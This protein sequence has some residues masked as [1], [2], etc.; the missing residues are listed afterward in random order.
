[1]DTNN[2]RAELAEW[3]VKNKGYINPEKQE[4]ELQKMAAQC[5]EATAQEKGLVDYVDKAYEVMLIMTQQTAP[6]VRQAA[7]PTTPVSGVTAAEEL[8]IANTLMQQQ[9]TRNAV[10]A[11]SSIESLVFDRPDPSTYIAAGTTGLIVE[12]SWKNFMDKITNGTYTVMPDDGEDVEASKRILSTTNFEKLKAAQAAGQPVQIHIGGL[13]TRPIGYIS[14]VGSNTGA[15]NTP[16]QMTRAMM[17]QFVVMDTAGYILASDTKPGVKLRFVS[18]KAD[19]SQPGKR[20]PGKTILADTNKKAAVEAGSY[21]ISKE[22][23]AEK[24]TTTCKAVDCIRVKVAGKFMKDGITPQVRTIRMSVKADLPVLVR[25]PEFIDVFG[26]GERNSNA[27]LTEIPTGDQAKKISEA[28]RN[29][30]AMLRQK[31]QDPAAVVELADISDK[32]AA[33]DVKPAQSPAAVM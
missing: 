25:K 24:Q 15:A 2:K 14:N 9:A 20:S 13:T 33:F 30:I 19:P 17:E 12:K 23:T 1:M 29:A 31:A 32:L 6:T 28:Q 21:V 26:T 11:N 7:V 8:A 3:L 10:S 5:P 16:R 27:D 18:G 4:E 22:P